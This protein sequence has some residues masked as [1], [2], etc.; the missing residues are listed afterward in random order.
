MKRHLPKLFFVLLILALCGLPVFG[1]VSNAGS[2]TGSVL[3]PHGAVVPDASVTVKNNTTGLARTT[4]TS[5]SGLF[6]IPSL[7][8][9]VYTVTVQATSGFKK[10]EVTK[11]KVEIGTPATVNVALELGNPQETVTVVGG[12]EVLQTQSATVGTTIS[13]RQITELPFTS[14]DSLD[15]VLML[16]GTATPARPRSSTVDGLPKGALTITLDGVPD[17]DEGQKSGDGFFAYVR[18]RIDA[19]EEIQVTSAAS[20]ADSTGDGAIQL[21]FNTKAGTSE[22][23]GSGYWYHRNTWLN[24]NYYF[25]NLAGIPRQQMILNQPGFRIGGPIMFPHL[26]KS[27]D[28]AFFFLNYEEFRLPAST[29]RSRNILSTSAATGV[30]KY[31][32]SG[33]VNLLT[34]AASKGQTSTIDP[35]ISSL[36]SA[37]RGSLGS[38][39]VS[40]L[41]VNQDRFNFNSPSTSVRKFTTVRFDFNLT[42]KHHL[43]EI[44]NYNV[45]IGTP[46]TLNNADNSFPGLLAGVGGQNS[47]RWSNAIA[48]RSTLKSNLVNELRFGYGDGGTVLFRP[49]TGAGSFS[50]LGGYAT[51]FTVFAPGNNS[52]TS[53]F[54]TN[55]AS[56]N[57]TPAK[58]ITDN[59]SY[60]RGDHSFSFGGDV[61]QYNFWTFALNRF[62]PA[63]TFGL[64]SNDPA[65]AAIFCSTCTPVNFPGASATDITNAQNLYALLTGRVT[66]VAANAYVSEETGKYTYLGDFTDRNRQRTAGIYGQDSWRLK[67]NLT[68]NL[69]LRWQLQAPPVSLNSNY[70]QTTYEGLWGVSGVGNLFKPGVVAPAT[71]FTQV[72]PKTHLYNTDWNNF[73]PS[74]GFAWSPNVKNGVMRRLMGESGQTVIRAGY[75]IAFVREGLS[76]VQSLFGANPGG[77]LNA[78][79]SVALGNLAAGTLYRTPGALT[80]PAIPSAPAYP[81]APVTGYSVTDSANGFLPDLKTGYVHS[82]SF[83]IQRELTKDTVLEV[84]YVGNRGRD[85]WKQYNLD[86]I[87]LLENGFLNEFKVA[88]ANL[89]AQGG[90]NFRYSPTVAGTAPLPIMAAFFGGFTNAQAVNCTAVSVPS[91]ATVYGSTN[92]AA[93]A[94]SNLLLANNANPIGFANSLF[95]NS[96]RRA[97]ALAAGLPSNFFV[98][99]PN[100]LGTSTTVPG[101]AFIVDNSGKTWY[102]SLQI[103]VRRRMAKGLL[104]QG[105]YTFSKALSNM[106]ASSTGVFYQPD[107]LRNLALDKVESPWDLRHAIKAS[108]I[109]ELPFGRG[110]SFLNNANGLV[111]RLAGG[112]AIH[113]QARVQSGSAFSYGNVQLV[114]MTKQELQHAIKIRK[115]PTGSATVFYLP[116][117]IMQNTIKAFNVCFPGSTG[118]NAQGYSTGTLTSGLNSFTGGTP[119]GR[120]IAPASSNGCVQGYVGQCGFGNLVLYGPRFSRFDISLVKKTKI[121]ETVNFE[122]RTEFLNA[123]NN[124]NFKIGSQSAEVTSVGGFSGS[125]FGTTANAYQ[126][127]STTNDPG[128]RMIQIVVR[129]NF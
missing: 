68:V 8:V 115:V 99:N 25:N 43:E 77:I 69:G 63:V 36:L 104:I 95:V 122:V 118:C 32:T 44:W 40:F 31:G 66:S 17:Q 82:W 76:V 117:D 50:Y 33:S 119:T 87:N 116:D 18:P 49:E 75:S 70:S 35:T 34:L 107:T 9:G 38:G 28:K 111:D 24:A 58:V 74:L 42:K 26:I 65:S 46:D 96:G 54:A 123:F 14:R 84:R 6:T 93:A 20:G 21:K 114:G 101:G 12:G 100:L 120:Y 47:L 67:P 64:D 5:E 112:W 48:L 129:L 92:F 79:R 80:P 53:P 3:D 106:Y 39:A 27:R 103:E 86:E 10:A 113:G 1:Q 89:R 97:N 15:L 102:D 22:Y 83:G 29:A 127:L 52:T 71:V 124:I 105:S 78:T 109:Y 57:H 41:N 56:R 11:V 23:H 59:L 81:L 62:V 121:T 7:P 72:Q 2:I 37:I 60:V 73:A 16:P 4:T 85:L 128:G 91:C 98:A 51:S 108:W 110:H 45:F 30:F 88:Q 61:A 55:S 126:D 125:T 13:G 19:I 94:F 90:A